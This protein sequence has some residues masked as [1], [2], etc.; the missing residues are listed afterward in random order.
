MVRVHGQVM[1]RSLWKCKRMFR[2]SFR[3]LPTVL[4]RGNSLLPLKI[5]T[6]PRRDCSLSF[7]KPLAFPSCPSSTLLLPLSSAGSLDCFPVWTVPGRKRLGEQRACWPSFFFSGE[8]R[9]IQLH[10]QV[11]FPRRVAKHVGPLLRELR[12]HSVMEKPFK[13]VSSEPPEEARADSRTFFFFLTSRRNLQRSS[14]SSVSSCLWKFRS[15]N[16]LRANFAFLVVPPK[17][18]LQACD[19]H[20][21]GSTSP[22][23]WIRGLDL[24]NGTSSAT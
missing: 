4:P 3:P 24:Y 12:Q 8:A 9:L 6:H 2:I 11:V 20:M 17:I 10:W 16:L 7:G 1:R 5:Q 15:S 23:T 13:S 19:K 21:H 18:M 22:W 14:L